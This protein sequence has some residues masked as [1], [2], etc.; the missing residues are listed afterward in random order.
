MISY[1]TE[2]FAAERIQ[3]MIEEAERQRMVRRASPDRPAGRPWR[4]TL[5]IATAIV[6]RIGRVAHAT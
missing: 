6:R 4:A 3:D 5:S 1:Q 2:M